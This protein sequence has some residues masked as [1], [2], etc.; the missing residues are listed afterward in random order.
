MYGGTRDFEEGIPNNGVSF[1]SL[2]PN[3]QSS[4][5]FDIFCV[6]FRLAHIAMPE[7]GLGD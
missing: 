2:L 6:A 3:V 7:S 4:F 1:G 5:D